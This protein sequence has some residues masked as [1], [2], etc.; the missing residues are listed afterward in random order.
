M[1]ASTTQTNYR[2][3]GHR[4]EQ[5]SYASAPFVIGNHE[6]QITVSPCTHGLSNI[7]PKTDANQFETNYYWRPIGQ[8]VWQHMQRWPTYNLNDGMYGGCPRGLATLFEREKPAL[9]KFFPRVQREYEASDNGRQ[10]ALI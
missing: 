5:V 9:A 4:N 2:Q 7:L 8:T 10:M 1:S 6:W 3:P